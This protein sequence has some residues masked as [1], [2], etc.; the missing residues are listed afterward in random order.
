MKT[1]EITVRVRTKLIPDNILW[2]IT[3]K[4]KDALP[5]VSIE[6]EQLHDIPTSTEHHGGITN[7]VSIT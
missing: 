2:Y 5:V 4:I 7:E 1:Y 3:E 6:V